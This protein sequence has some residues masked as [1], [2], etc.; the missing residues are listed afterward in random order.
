M[1]HWLENSRNFSRPYKRR[2]GKNGIRTA[3]EGFVARIDGNLKHFLGFDWP[4]FKQEV[5]RIVH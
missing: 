4:F 5:C 1:G 3:P 2:S